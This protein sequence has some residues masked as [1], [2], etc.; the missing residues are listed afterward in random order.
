MEHETLRELT[1]AYA[2]DALGPDDERE[3]EEHLAR[4]PLCREDVAAFREAAAALAYDVEAPV[5]PPA[6][7]D[8]I[9]AQARAERPNVLPLHPRWAFRVTVAAAAVAAGAAIGLGIWAAG[10][11]SDLSD[12]R[13]AAAKQADV[14]S[15]LASAGSREVP[16]SGAEGSLVVAEDG[17]AVLVVAGLDPAPAGKAYEV[18][19]IAGDEAPAPAGLFDTSDGSAAVLLDEPVADGAVVAVTVEDEVGVE[20]PTGEPILATDAV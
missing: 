15:I 19:V 4:C 14:V 6:L 16:L 8:R 9:V 2:L 13:T 20:A 11:R 7:R 12:E 3:F 17:R 18:W 5:P 1:A 10:L